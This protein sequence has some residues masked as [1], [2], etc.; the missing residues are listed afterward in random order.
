MVVISIA[1]MDWNHRSHQIGTFRARGGRRQPDA[2][3][4]A[5]R[6]RRYLMTGVIT[7]ALAVTGCSAAGSSNTHGGNGNPAKVTLK[8]QMKGQTG[9]TGNPESLTC[10]PTGANQPGAAAAC[11]S[12]LKL[13]KNPFA[14]IAKGIACPMLLRSNRK[15]LVTGTWFGITVHRVVVDGGCDTNLFDSLDKIF[16]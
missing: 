10:D 11:T 7:A 3:Q 6:A 15:I 9:N 12:L 8:F 5:G 16:H 1:F 4:P 14:P 13:K 2:R